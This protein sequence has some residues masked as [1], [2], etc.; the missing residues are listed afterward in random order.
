V[1]NV[2]DLLEKADDALYECKRSGRNNVISYA[3]VMSQSSVEHTSTRGY[4]VKPGRSR[5][6]DKPI[7]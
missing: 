4:E 3:S 6:T 7:E 1:G 2:F 5:K